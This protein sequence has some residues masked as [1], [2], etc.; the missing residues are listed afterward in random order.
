MKNNKITASIHQPNFLPWIGY[1]NKIALS[2]KFVFF[3]DVQFP[4]SKSFGNRV[5]IKSN[6]GPI[7]ITVPV[8]HKGS[9]VN[10][11]EIQVDNNQDWV[12]KTLKT[13]K[14]FYSKAPNF[15]LFI[16][17]FE[18]IY[19][20]KYDLLIDLNTALIRF[21]SE[22]IDL[23]TEFFN[24]SNL[25]DGHNCNTN[26][27]ILKILKEINATYYLSGTGA[28][29]LKY[30]DEAAFSKANIKLK[31]QKVNILPYPQLFGDFVPNLSIIDLFFNLGRDSKNYLL[32]QSLIKSTF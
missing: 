32:N 21:I 28:G 31:W 29:S 25:S 13:I 18:Q 9:L 6:A 2:D 19:T 5:L 20:I 14:L 24:S 10:F 23:K 26:E 1:F 4:R 12:R 27:K 3:D 7:W 11:N 22:E 30:I 17:T 15:K 16:D 8:L